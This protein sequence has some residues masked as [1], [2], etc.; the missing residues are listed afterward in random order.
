MTKSVR[1]IPAILTNDPLLLQNMLQQAETFTDY[2][3]IDIM[4]GH[5]VP[6]QSISWEQI[7]GIQK[8]IEWEV[9]LMV[10]QPEKQLENFK[11]A[12]ALKAI[13]H[14]EATYSPKRAIAIA[15]NL[16]IEIGLAINP[17]TPVSSILSLTEDIDSVLF[18]SVHPGFYGAQFIP[19]VLNK[20]SEIRLARP[21]LR[22]GI[23]GGIKESNIVQISKSG[24]DEICVGSAIF[25]QPLPGES[26]RKL[27]ELA[28]HDSRA[29]KPL[30]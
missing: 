19:G 27:L 18:L 4:D 13:F 15:R 11:I 7:T 6:S 16:G 8:E 28:N 1:V 10:E 2:V 14:Y 3:Q 22:I 17:E 5:F 29:A 20:I 26:Y 21:T 30:L 9:H 23:D 12:G 25:N 24:V